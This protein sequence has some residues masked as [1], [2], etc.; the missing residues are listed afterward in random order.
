MNVKATRPFVIGFCLIVTA[1]TSA[2]TQE[3]NATDRVLAFTTGCV[4]AI[5]GGH[6]V[7]AFAAKAGAEPAPEQLAQTLLGKEAGEVYVKD[8][9]DYPVAVAER[10]GGCSV[11]ARILGDLAPLIEAADD[12][13][14]G[15]GGRFY[16]VRAYEEA[17]GTAGWTTHYIY[18]GKRAKKNLTVVLSTT[19]GADGFDRV[20]VTVAEAKR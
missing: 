18:A 16:R 1:A 7:H 17:S 14:A 5:A 12:F 2:H 15:P 4:Q 13:I 20:T 19:P 6:S 3:P 8:D 11:H 10:A 9:P